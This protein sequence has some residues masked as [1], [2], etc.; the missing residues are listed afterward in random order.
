MRERKKRAT[1]EALSWEAL[2]LAA[3]RGIENVLVED[4]AA[5]AGVSPRTFN[6]Y[7]A[8]KYEAIVWRELDRMV[9]IGDILRERPPDEPFW[10]SIEHAV[11]AIYS[12]DGTATPPDASWTD[13]VRELVSSPLLTAEFLKA[14]AAMTRALAEA[15]AD[16]LGMDVDRDMYPRVVAGSVGAVCSVA[17]EQ[18]MNADPP[19]ALGPLVREALGYLIQG[20]EP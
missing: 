20:G 4:I 14:D 10:Q 2:R 7:F 5:A 19:V 18:W 6:N 16:R 13:A 17:Q 3:E 12:G 11:L 8:S 9:R 1:R 15:I